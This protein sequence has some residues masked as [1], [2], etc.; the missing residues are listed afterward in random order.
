MSRVLLIRKDYLFYA[1]FYILSGQNL[2]TIELRFCVFPSD[3]EECLYAVLK[4]NVR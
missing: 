2:E 4:L 3:L 1:P